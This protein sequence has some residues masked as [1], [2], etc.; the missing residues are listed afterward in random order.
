MIGAFL[1]GL[2][3]GGFAGL[4][5]AALLFANEDERGGRQ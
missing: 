2:F 3:I 1:I 5:T 4:I